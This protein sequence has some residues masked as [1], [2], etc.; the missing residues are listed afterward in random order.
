MDTGWVSCRNAARRALSLDLNPERDIDPER[1][2]RYINPP[3]EGDPSRNV[4]RGGV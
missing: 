2:V 4:L 3:P 1:L